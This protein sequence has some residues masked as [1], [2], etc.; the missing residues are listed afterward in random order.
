MAKA[1][2]PGKKVSSKNS[3]PSSAAVE[4]KKH[5]ILKCSRW[6]TDASPSPSLCYGMITLAWGHKAGMLQKDLAGLVCL[7]AYLPSNARTYSSKLR[8]GTGQGRINVF[9]NP[10]GTTILFSNLA[11]Y[12]H[13]K[14]WETQG[15]FHCE[16][17]LMLSF[18]GCGQSPKSHTW[19]WVPRWTFLST[20]L[21]CWSNMEARVRV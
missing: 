12:L 1:N 21:T 16:H 3:K 13:Q 7:C 4:A 9:C 20:L 2:I 6:G 10:V 17:R 15:S 19:L 11:T 18:Q 14:F 5:R 8:E